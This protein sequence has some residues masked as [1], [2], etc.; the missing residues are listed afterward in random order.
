[1]ITTETLGCVQPTM[2]KERPTMIWR[3]VP[4]CMVTWK[5][6]FKVSDHQTNMSSGHRDSVFTNCHR[7]KRKM[8]W[9]GGVNAVVAATKSARYARDMK[10]RH[11]PLRLNDRGTNPTE[12]K[13]THGL[14]YKQPKT[15]NT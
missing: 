13:T 5:T 11:C 14:R 1:M 7:G 8:M 10:D 15:K 9:V 6:R 2:K 4:W 3:S 12:Y